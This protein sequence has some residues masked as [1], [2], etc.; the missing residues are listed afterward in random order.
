[1]LRFKM[2]T[3]HYQRIPLNSYPT[4]LNS[5]ALVWHTVKFPMLTDVHTVQ[6]TTAMLHQCSQPGLSKTRC[7]RGHGLRFPLCLGCSWRHAT[8]DWPGQINLRQS[9]LKT[10]AECV[11]FL[12]AVLSLSLSPL[13]PCDK[14]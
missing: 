4:K 12:K 13:F 5:F 2:H 11:L 10:I 3:R 7:E 14:S 8:S 1:M 9:Y 6:R